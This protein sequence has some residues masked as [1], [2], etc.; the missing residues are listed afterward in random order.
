MKTL[1]AIPFLNPFYDTSPIPKVKPF[2]WF[3]YAIM[4]AISLGIVGWYLYG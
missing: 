3:I 1:K 2:D 4:S